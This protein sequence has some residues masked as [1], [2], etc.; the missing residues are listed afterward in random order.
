MKIALIVP[1]FDNKGPVIVAKDLCECFIKLGH[2]CHV[3]YFNDV[4][5]LKFPCESTKINFFDK[6]NFDSFDIVHSHCIKPNLFLWF[7]FRNAKFKLKYKFISTLHQP[8]TISALWLGRKNIIAILLFFL[9]RISH[10]VFDKNVFLSDEQL[11]LSRNN[12][13][14]KSACIIGNGRT[15]LKNDII[16]EVDKNTILELKERYHIVGTVSVIIKRKGIEQLIYAL[17]RL[18]N[19]AAVIVGDGDELASLKK[20]AIKLNVSDRCFWTGYR[21]DGANYI[22]YFDVYTLTTRSEGFPLAYI[23]AAAYEKPVVLS[24]IPILRAIADENVSLFYELDNI[25]N[26]GDKILE[27]Y[28]NKEILSKNIASYYDANLTAEKMA[29]KYIELYTT[30]L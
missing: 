14:I 15:L 16:D 28:S 19:W 4:F 10:S 6:I 9:D 30:I 24:D 13:D 7:H 23:E 21:F 18:D 8:L 1:S 26:L 25:E 27:A 17:T 5:K 22:Q 2:S 3:Y 29:Q 12:I 20:L 11:R